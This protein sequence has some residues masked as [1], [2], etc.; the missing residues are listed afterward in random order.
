MN[1]FSLK[2]SVFAV[3]SLILSGCRYHAGYPITHS[4][5]QSIYVAPAVN[6]AVVAQM[7]GVL[8]S[9]IREEITHLG[10]AT[11]GTKTD[12]DAT[13]ETTIINYGR[14]IG[15]VDEYDTDTAKTLSLNATI[16]C[17]LKNNISGEYFFKDKTFSASLSINATD[18]AQSIEYQRLPQLSRK[19]AKQL[20]MLIAN[21]DKTFTSDTQVNASDEH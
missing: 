13:L 10:L 16:R 12:S 6:E 2:I 8:S 18:S 5:I 3:L 19:L 11:L 9:Q 20:V 4:G 14:S 7:S 15:T 1:K 17:S 21:M